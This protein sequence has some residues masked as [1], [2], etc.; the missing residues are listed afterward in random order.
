[1]T[2]TPTRRRPDTSSGLLGLLGEVRATIVS[3]LADGE[4]TVAELSDL[5]GISQVAVRR[6]LTRLV[7]EGWISGRTDAPDGPGRPVTR[8]Q[9]T[10][11]GHELLPQ[12]YAALAA[13]LLAYIDD[14]AGQEG[15]TAYLDWR[16]RRRV[17]RLSTTVDADTIDARLAQLA[18]ALTDIGST[19]TVESTDDGFVLR[20]HHCTVM[21]VARQH[22]QLCQA[23]AV[24]FSRVIGADVTVHRGA[25]RATGDG[26][27]ECAVIAVD[28][29]APTDRAVLPMA[30]A[31]ATM[32]AAP[33]DAATRNTSS[34]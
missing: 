15:L 21:D 16:A 26:T 24:E 30:A 8:Y 14:T 10:A 12:G 27:C 34:P 25:S 3:S 29:L 13:E 1:M 28:D 17:Q 22:P 5:L 4:R 9:L 33:A 7:D 18:E 19:A 11:D 23:E 20:Q 6:H 32:T 31:S 2:Q